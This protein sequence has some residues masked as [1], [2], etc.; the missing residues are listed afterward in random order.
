MASRL[1]ILALFLLFPVWGAWPKYVATARVEGEP[2]KQILLAIFHFQAFLANISYITFSFASLAAKIFAIISAV[3]YTKD[4]EGSQ[5][6]ETL[7]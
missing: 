6:L 2:G 1:A 3:I 7:N 5:L 4:L